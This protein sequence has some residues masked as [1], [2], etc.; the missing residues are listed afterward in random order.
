[1][2][3]NGKDV[4]GNECTR[5]DQGSIVVDDQETEACMSYYKHLLTNEPEWDRNHLHLVE[6]TQAPCMNTNSELK[7][8]H[9]V[10]DI[11]N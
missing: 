10:L 9:P 6:S 11:R 8:V 2:V 7:E 4:L 5:N 1:M 3:K